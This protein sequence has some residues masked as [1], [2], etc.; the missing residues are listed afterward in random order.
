[1]LPHFIRFFWVKISELH[2]LH[3]S[4]RNTQIFLPLYP[5]FQVQNKKTSNSQHIHTHIDSS[6]THTHSH[7]HTGESTNQDLGEARGLRVQLQRE[8]SSS[9]FLTNL[10]LDKCTSLMVISLDL[11]LELIK[12]KQT[13][14][15][16]PYHESCE[17]V[18]LSVMSDPLWPHGL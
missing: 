6:H 3:N 8:V 13:N 15:K 9:P 11:A 16:N 12:E 7:I 10:F 1:M 5:S 17:S 4:E 2:S 18:S 14:K